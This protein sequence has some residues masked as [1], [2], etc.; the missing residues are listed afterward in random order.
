M[1][2]IHVKDKKW[3][4]TCVYMDISFILRLLGKC[5]LYQLRYFLKILPYPYNISRNLKGQFK[6]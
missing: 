3:L 5:V 4:L 6:R 1:G 2:E